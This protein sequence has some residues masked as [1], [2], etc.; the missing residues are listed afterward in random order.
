MIL[1]MWHERQCA[2]SAPCFLAL[3]AWALQAVS[4]DL[5]PFRARRLAMLAVQVGELKL[6]Y[7]GVSVELWIVVL[8][9]QSS[10]CLLNKYTM[11]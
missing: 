10:A 11:F 7:M 1:Q 3:H 2:G 5:V 4:W 6:S 9:K 8:L